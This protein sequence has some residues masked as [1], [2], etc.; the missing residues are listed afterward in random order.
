MTKSQ[1]D[2]PTLLIDSRRHEGA[3]LS[4][5]FLTKLINRYSF[6]SAVVPFCL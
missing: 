2:E 1:R 3:R 4:H 6:C 5:S